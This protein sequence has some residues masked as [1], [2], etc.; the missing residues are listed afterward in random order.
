[1]LVAQLCPTL[2]DP[3]DCSRPGSLVHGILQAKILEWVA[4]P[5]SRSSQPRD[6]TQGSHTAVGFFTIWATREAQA[7]PL[8]GIS[9]L[10]VLIYIRVKV[11]WRSFQPCHQVTSLIAL[12]II[13][14][15]LATPHGFGILVPPTQGLNLGPQQWKLRVLTTGLLGIPSFSIFKVDF[16]CI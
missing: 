2:C 11:S 6:R 14:L 5:F 3:M 4:I 8:N 12:I 15:F 10:S 9:F 7:P 1:M 16:A 13:F